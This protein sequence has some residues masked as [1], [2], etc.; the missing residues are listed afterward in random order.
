MEFVVT[1]RNSAGNLN[2]RLQDVPFE[3][4]PGARPGR[5]T[6][7][8]S[9]ENMLSINPNLYEPEALLNGAV[10]SKTAPVSRLSSRRFASL[11]RSRWFPSG[12]TGS[13]R[14]GPH[15]VR[16]LVF[17]VLGFLDDRDPA[18]RIVPSWTRPSPVRDGSSQAASTEQKNQ[19]TWL[20]VPPLHTSRCEVFRSSL[21]LTNLRRRER[22]LP[23]RFTEQN[24]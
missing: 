4:D 3:S 18:K 2:L 11:R 22:L 19:C 24:N 16:A 17:S 8:G 21:L 12:P 1:W 9:R 13:Q 23:G 14:L 6:S 5:D 20:A 15:S 7:R 10:S